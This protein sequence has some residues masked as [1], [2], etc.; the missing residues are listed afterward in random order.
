MRVGHSRFRR[1]SAHI[2]MQSDRGLVVYSRLMKAYAWIVIGVIGVL[3]LT[4]S[5]EFAMGRLPFGPDGRFGWWEGNIWS[6]EQ[7]QRFA[8]P[9][10]FSHVV[11]G[12]MFYCLLWLLA[13]KVPARYRFLLAVI[14]EAGW[15]ILENSPFIINRYRAVTIALGYV[16]DSL[17][18][19]LSDILMMSLGFLFAMRVRVRTSVALVVLIEGGML[20]WVR[21]NLSL[22]L[23]MLIHPIETVRTWQMNGRPL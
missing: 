2:A 13:R 8:D 19:S 21:D 3:A 12:V 5:I 10:S 4:A 6:H 1:L 7:S 15:E 16:G 11:H 18:N 9:Y 23:I 17:I 14:L 20:L 22:N